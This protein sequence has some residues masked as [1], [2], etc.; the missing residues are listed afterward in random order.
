MRI[1]FFSR[2]FVFV[3]IGTLASGFAMNMQYIARGWFVFGIG[4]LVVDLA[5]VLLAFTL[6]QVFFSLPGGI[7]ADRYSKRSIIVVSHALIAI[8]TLVMG[9]L[10]LGHHIQFIHFI[11]FGVLNGTVLALSFP[12]RQ[13]IVPHVVK[14]DEV[15]S[16]LALNSTA[17][18][19][20]RVAGPAFAGVLIAWIVESNNQSSEIAVGVVYLVIS[21]LYFLAALFSL[22]ITVP[23]RV[24]KVSNK[25]SLKK[26]LF[27]VAEFVLHKRIVFSLVL[28]SIFAYMFGHSLNAFLPAFN[29]TVLLGTAREYGFL[30]TTL[31]IGSIVGSFTVVWA[32]ELRRKGIWLIGLQMTWG[33]LVFSFGFTRW[34]WLAF[35]LSG[36]IGWFAGAAMALNRSLLQSHVRTSL[37]GRVMSID[38]M[39]H[40]MMPFA[41]LPLGMLADAKGIDFALSVAGGL[42]VLTI[43]LAVFGVGAHR[44]ITK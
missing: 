42:L 32:S 16:A 9:L 38:M 22:S 40:G 12:A 30:V 35:V 18:N 10:I 43:A 5:W 17:V 20:S 23:G 39:A 6:P 8:A 36:L 31:G 25:L 28:L 34:M 13:A 27:E 29:E 33:A 7:L 2:D 15:F 26:D 4:N 21:S 41:A 19:I 14:E 24:A 1:T 44:S 37:L 11:V 3:W